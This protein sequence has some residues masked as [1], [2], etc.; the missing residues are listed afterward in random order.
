MKIILTKARRKASALLTTLVI[1][2]ILC[3]FVLFYLAL[4]D[5]QSFLGARS[6]TWNLAI[7]I[8]E[9][10]IEDGLQHINANYPNLN[11]DGWVYDGSTYYSRT[12]GLPDGSTY[13]AYVYLTN[14]LNP[15]IVSRS[16]VQ[17]PVQ[18]AH[19]GAI[20]VT[21]QPSV[22]S[23][24]VMATTAKA[25]MFIAAVVAKQSINLNGNN[26]TIDSFDS[27]YPG[28]KSDYNGLYNA[29]F[30][31]G[32][33][34]DVAVNQN[35][36]NTLSVGNANIYGHA[37]TGPNGSS[38]LNIN[39]GG[40]GEHSWQASH[41]GVES[42]WWS[43]DANFTI[44]DCPFPNTAGYFTPTGGVYVSIS[45]NVAATPTTSGVLPVPLPVGTI[46]TNCVSGTWQ[47][48]KFLPPLPGTYCGAVTTNGNKYS[49]YSKLGE[50][51]TY[52]LLA[53]NSYYV[54]NTY[55]YIFY[56]SANATNNYVLPNAL[57]GTSI[58]TGPNVNIALP[59][60]INLSGGSDS[61]TVV[62]GA[63]VTVYAKNT[64]S[65]GGNGM[66]NAS[67]IANN[68][69][70]YCDPS[71]TDVALGGNG[72]FKGALVAPEANIR[73]NGSGGSSVNDITGC[74]I[75][76]S[77]TFNGQFNVHYDE[78]L[79]RNKANGRFLILS[80]NEVK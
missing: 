46:V 5:Q 43:Q 1:C 63:N 67:G 11:C 3:T 9:A 64:V 30:Y 75:A 73:L 24:A 50:T 38:A 15:V 49:Y 6:Q 33:H 76:N 58:V 61:F 72:G 45:N 36:A 56:G 18:V 28:I 13:V 47:A 22:V 51:Y 39:N 48:D 27:G 37:H 59:N 31:T 19:L 17:E 60:G 66:I 26:V 78:A 12:N 54:T 14:F 4:I 69:I 70:I 16:Y 42:G 44:P 80:W 55:N 10:G 25:N 29:S 65:V 35:I 52:N 79:S 7:A 74:I 23:R 20:G 40:V 62:S 57:Q 8:S 41:T 21:P 77:V 34:G 53:T 32:D 71:V 68:M 2:S